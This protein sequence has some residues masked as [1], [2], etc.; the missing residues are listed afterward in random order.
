MFWLLYVTFACFKFLGFCLFSYEVF[1]I[2]IWCVFLWVCTCFIELLHK[3]VLEY[4]NFL[5]TLL[6]AF[7]SSVSVVFAN[8]FLLYPSYFK[9][10]AFE[11]HH[12]IL[13]FFCRRWCTKNISF[14]A[15]SKKQRYSERSITPAKSFHSIINFYIVNFLMFIWLILPVV[16]HLS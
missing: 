3:D 16:I 14:F 5:T 15:Y 10:V 9:I 1:S 6:L 8:F 7:H 12:R 13:F 2:I 11:I 4:V